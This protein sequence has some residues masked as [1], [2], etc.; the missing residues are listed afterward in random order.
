MS[1]VTILDT[2]L[3]MLW[4]PLLAN[5]GYWH[6]YLKYRSIRKYRAKMNDIAIFYIRFDT[7]NI[8]TQ[9]HMWNTLE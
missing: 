6:E 5:N 9:H 8:S 7:L 4:W 1:R 2:N 3:L